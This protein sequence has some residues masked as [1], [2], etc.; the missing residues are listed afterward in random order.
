MSTAIEKLFAIAQSEDTV[1]FSVPLVYVKGKTIMTL[2]ATNR[3]QY[4]QRGSIKDKYK[5]ILLPIVTALKKFDSGHI[6]MIY[7]ITYSDRRSRD[8]DNNIYVTKWLQDL[9]VEEGILDDDKHVSFTYLPYKNDPSLDEHT[10]EVTAI[11]LNA[12][13]YFKR[14]KDHDTKKL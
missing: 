10:C 1:V 12:N 13:D 14:I 3:M 6:H 11:D 9:M 2:N 7:Q 5:K 8:M 4:H